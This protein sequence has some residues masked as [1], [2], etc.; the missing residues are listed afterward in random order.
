MHKS[1][2]EFISIQIDCCKFEICTLIKIGS[3]NIFARYQPCFYKKARKLINSVLSGPSA[4]YS[5][6]R[7][8][9]QRDLSRR[10]TLVTGSR[11]K[12]IFRGV[13][14][15]Q[16]LLNIW[17]ICK[18]SIHVLCVPP[19]AGFHP[20]HFVCRIQIRFRSSHYSGE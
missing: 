13:H 3:L 11:G 9:Q 8:V 20:S 15:T 6:V 18:S 12:E 17:R 4:E 10:N 5:G 1:N 16:I 19:S 14:K 2:N 7:H